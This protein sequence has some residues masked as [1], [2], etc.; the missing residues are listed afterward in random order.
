[1][2]DEAIRRAT[3]VAPT[4]HP[5]IDVLQVT[6]H[7][8]SLMMEGTFEHPHWLGQLGT[9]LGNDGVSIVAGSAT[10]TATYSWLANFELDTSGASATFGARSIGFA[11]RQPPIRAT[12]EVRLLGW[13]LDRRPQD[14]LIHLCVQAADELGFLGALLRRLAVLALVPVELRVTTE[15]DRIDDEFVLA[16]VGGAA[17]TKEVEQALSQMLPA[18]VP[19]VT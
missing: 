15:A 17:P 10:R 14:D 8:A 1:V 7:R 13:S 16:R 6:S 19:S 5:T 2:H 3:G 11:L 9:A 4:R 12:S 18:S